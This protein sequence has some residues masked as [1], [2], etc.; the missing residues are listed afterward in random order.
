MRK[1]I[2]SLTKNE[3]GVA[4]V[5]EAIIIFPIMIL[6]IVF[7]IYLGNGVYQTSKVSA[8]V[9]RYA[10]EGAQMCTD[11]YYY[12][13]QKSNDAVPSSFSAGVQPYRYILQTDKGHIETVK[14]DMEKKLEDSI[15]SHGFFLG[16][17][18]KISYKEISY[19]NHVVYSTFSVEVRYSIVM[20]VKLFGEH[21]F[22][23]LKSSAYSEVAVNDPAEFIR[24]TNMVIDLIQKT[25][26]GSAITQKI[27][28]A[29]SKVQEFI[30]KVGG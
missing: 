4:T 20:G 7:L 29:M 13:V 2:S 18:P 21:D 28:E 1:I 24:N 6:V 30:N 12:D 15:N 26:T 27:S 19:N 17:K 25:E 23:I 14:R 11:P 22:R 9:A 16:M 5:M 10:V 3:R 8:A